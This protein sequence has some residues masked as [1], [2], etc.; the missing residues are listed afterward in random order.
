[1]KFSCPQCSTFYNLPDNSLPK[2]TG[3][4]D[5]H[6]MRCVK[7]NCTFVLS[8]E[9]AAP[10][11]ATSRK[12]PESTYFELLSPDSLPKLNFK[13]ENFLNGTSPTHVMYQVQSASIEVLN[14]PVKEPVT[15]AAVAWASGAPLDLS[16]YELRRFAR[17]AQIK[18]SVAAALFFIILGFFVFIAASNGWKISINRFDQQV[19]RTFGLL[20]AEEEEQNIM[21]MLKVN[22]EKGYPFRL[23]KGRRVGIIVGNIQN[24]AP[25]NVQN[26]LLKGVLLN[27]QRQIVA[28]TILPCGVI[29]PDR[30]IRRTMNRNIKKLYMVDHNIYNCEIKSGFNEKFKVIFSEIPKDFDSSFVFQIHLESASRSVSV[31]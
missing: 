20:T 19:K 5:V 25:Y 16:E 31:K 7:C 23:K 28:T 4:S 13:G 2:I 12:P 17:V 21:S 26:V 15:N 6:K 18:S 8:V 3:E 10:D 29:I 24:N 1:M 30:K 14:Q 9:L 22:L 11:I 27:K